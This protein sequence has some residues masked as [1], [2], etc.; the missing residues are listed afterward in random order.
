MTDLT[1]KAMLRRINEYD[2]AIHEMVL[3]LDTHPDSEGALKK[4]KTFRDSRNAAISAYT[5]KYGPYITTV[6]EVP[7]DTPVWTW[8]DGPWPWENESEEN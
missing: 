1:K 7:A 8:T 4:L 5:Q 2:F 6:N 3:F